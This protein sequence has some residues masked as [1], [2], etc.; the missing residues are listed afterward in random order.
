MNELPTSE[1]S[2]PSQTKVMAYGFYQM[3]VNVVPAYW[4]SKVA[5]GAWGYA[6]ITGRLPFP[7]LSLLFSVPCNLALITGE[8]SGNLFGGDCDSRASFLKVI[9][10]VL[11]EGLPLFAQ[12]SGGERGG[13]HVLFKY[14]DGTVVQIKE[15]DLVDFPEVGIRSEGNYL[16]GAGSCLPTGTYRL[17]EGN[18]V[19]EIPTLSL[20]ILRW[21]FPQLDL[22]QKSCRTPARSTPRLHPG[23]TQY[24]A[25][26]PGDDLYYRQ[27]YA[28]ACDLTANGYAS[29]EVYAWL[30][31]VAATSAGSPK[32]L[33]Q[34]EHTLA[35]A[36]HGLPRA[37]VALN[38]FAPS[39]GQNY[40]KNGRHG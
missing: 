34:I 19:D 8:T 23:T 13:G 39:G 17:Y 10:R 29:S 38:R 9:Q 1:H 30:Y 22:A 33:R 2:S 21:V 14:A 16:I 31:P 5:F 37:G 6:K 24:L 20:E 12:W 25:G 28:A 7:A 27:L 3:G 15:G 4:M 32:A 11:E 35:K 26:V 40:G 36:T 18:T